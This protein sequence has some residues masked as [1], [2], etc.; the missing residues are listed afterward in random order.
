[1]I[2]KL[3][4]KLKNNINI[5]KNFDITYLIDDFLERTIFRSMGAQAK[6]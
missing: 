4:N 6:I 3:N 2:K 1:M 5:L